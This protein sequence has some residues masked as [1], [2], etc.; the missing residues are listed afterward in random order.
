MNYNDNSIKELKTILEEYN[1]AIP[2]GAK[3]KDLV[4]LVEAIMAKD[5]DFVTMQVNIEDDI[6]EDMVE[7]NQEDV[8]VI[9]EIAGQIEEEK[10]SM[11]SDEWIDYVMGHF[12]KNELIDG[13]PICAGLRRVAELLLGDII[14]SGPETVFP[15][16]DGLS[17]GR[18][19]VV[20]KVVF[21]WMNSGENRIFKEVADVWHGNTDDLFCAHPAATAST[22]AEG[23]ALRKALKL[24]CLA[25]EELAKKDI[26]SIVKDS[27]KKAPAS[28]EYE[29]NTKIS[30]QQIQFIDN[31]CGQL[32]IDAFAFINMGNSSFA[33]VGE[34]TRDSAK[35][36]IKVLNTYQNDGGI[37][38]ENIKG[39]KT[40]WRE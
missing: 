1:C 33:N 4:E 40:N 13:N 17:P 37:I 22:R 27:I 25:A 21:N 32:D 9:K 23:R 15:S 30:S 8:T 38:P 12:K 3:K 20:F 2:S 14:E 6:F 18:A 34:V 24:R 19:T 10:P 26:V 29:S 31:K 16:T 39:H 7:E 28:G 36:M 35:K 11:F 5:E